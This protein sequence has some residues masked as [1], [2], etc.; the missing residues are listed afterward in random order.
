VAT[1][2]TQ[3]STFST[4][5]LRIQIKQ[6]SPRLDS[7]NQLALDAQCLGKYEVLLDRQC[8]VTRLR[9]CSPSSGATCMQ[10]LEP[11]SRSN[12]PLSG[13]R[14]VAGKEQNPVKYDLN[15]TISRGVVVEVVSPEVY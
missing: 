12:W 5:R 6:T 2:G 7:I 9:Y 13:G 15:D 3:Y 8:R 14:Q 10:M 1:L 4:S 11:G